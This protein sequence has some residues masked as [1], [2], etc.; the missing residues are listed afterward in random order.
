MLLIV[1][2]KL[3]SINIIF[4]QDVYIYFKLYNQVLSGKETNY[5]MFFSN[6]AIIIFSHF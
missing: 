6:K 1:H 3:R 5:F 2:V 4:I